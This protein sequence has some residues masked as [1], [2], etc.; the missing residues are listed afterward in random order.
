MKIENLTSQDFELAERKAKVLLFDIETTPLLMWAFDTFNANALKVEQDW[1]MLC[2]S[3]RWLGGKQITKAIWDYEG[4]E[5]K[6]TDDRALVADLWK[7]L[8]EADIVVGHNGRKFDV[9]KTQAK[10]IE[11]KFSP[12][13][14]FKIVDT[15]VESKRLA[16]FTSHR[17]GSLGEKL[18]IGEKLPTDKELWF[19]AMSGDAKAQK[20]MVRYCKQDTVLLEKLYLELRPYMRSHPNL[21]VMTDR[22]DGCRNCGSTHLQA[23]GFAFTATGKRQRYQCKSC[24]GW[25]QG[26]HHPVTTIR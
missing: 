2:W 12:L 26:K 8:E 5:P 14:P 20:R 17:L 1:Y 22:S 9:R 6:S 4:Y 13:P 23:R 19:S 10:G 25:M 16:S 3:A 24:G 11:Y 21:A 7:L 15:W 18:G